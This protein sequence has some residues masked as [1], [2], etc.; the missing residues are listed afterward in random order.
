M[1]K[2]SARASVAA[3]IKYGMAASLSVA[4]PY[5]ASAKSPQ[6]G[7][8]HTDMTFAEMRAVDPARKW[9]NKSFYDYAVLYTRA[10][11]SY[12]G[13][14]WL[15]RKFDVVYERTAYPSANL[16]ASVQIPADGFN[17]CETQIKQLAVDLDSALGSSPTAWSDNTP[18]PF[19][20]VD[21][22]SKGFE[23]F[24]P[25]E[26][27]YSFALPE[28]VPP[29]KTIKTDN[30]ISLFRIKLPAYPGNGAAD[31][32]GWRSYRMFDG[33]M[34]QLLA[35]YGANARATSKCLASIT[36]KTAAK[37]GDDWQRPAAVVVPTGLK[38]LLSD[39]TLAT[40]YAQVMTQQ[41]SQPIPKADSSHYI[42]DVDL[43][44][45]RLR[46]CHA[47]TEIAPTQST[48][49]DSYARFLQQQGRMK[50]VT[51][52]DDFRPRAAH[53][54]V[55]PVAVLPP[56]N[57]DWQLAQLD[58]LKTGIQDFQSQR[59]GGEVLQQF[60]PMESAENA[61]LNFKCH[62]MTDYS[63]FCGTMTVEPE[64]LQRR[65]ARLLYI[66]AERMAAT[67]VKSVLTNGQDAAGTYFMFRVVF[68]AS[69]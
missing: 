2:T 38:E 35:S 31:V 62:I 6:M 8:Y 51:D 15:G 12:G 23:Y 21:Q 40:G 34:V 66:V 4:T 30:K 59:I 45:G 20:N 49:L 48:V 47:N 68:R 50:I 58:A 25:F 13:L 42:C 32:I 52:D 56:R 46:Q 3:G 14:S 44:E 67:K 27:N 1:I 17:S 24:Y 22:L 61:I 65:Y 41:W 10:Q 29:T 5:A 43:A 9:L 19:G 69:S 60:A 54:K 63:V 18:L 36:V 7:P 33:E 37:Y 39:Y 28:A 11:Y 57:F 64:Q 26:A 16:I 53:I 55:E